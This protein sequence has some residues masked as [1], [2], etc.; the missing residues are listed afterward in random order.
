MN[1]SQ[2]EITLV[3][4]Q[5]KDWVDKTEKPDASNII[6]LVTLLIKCVENVAKDKDGAYKKNLVLTVLTKVIT[7][8]KLEPDAK[9]ALMVLVHTT[10]PVII[11]TMISI[12][13]KEIDLGKAKTEMSKCFCC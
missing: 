5:I 13:N 9:A 10:I 6:V 7:E 3:Y 11:D 2:D 8:S 12:A 4:N 1:P